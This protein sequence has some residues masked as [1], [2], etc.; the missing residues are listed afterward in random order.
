MKSYEVSRQKTLLLIR[1]TSHP[2]SSK[3]EEEEEEVRRRGHFGELDIHQFTNIGFFFIS[4]FSSAKSFF[5]ATLP[6]CERIA[7]FSSAL[8]PFLFSSSVCS[9]VHCAAL[10]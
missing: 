7:S 9:E 6:L 1:E 4:S 10:H 5:S 2:Y 8:W 3:E